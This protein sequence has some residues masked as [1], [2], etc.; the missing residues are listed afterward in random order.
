MS[1]GRLTDDATL[2]IEANK[3]FSQSQRIPRKPV[4][5]GSGSTA[6]S[7]STAEMGLPVPI[8]KTPLAETDHSAMHRHERLIRKDATP[9]PA[10]KKY[11]RWGVTWKTPLLIVLWTLAGVGWAIGHHLYYRSLDG[12]K[13]G[14]SSQQH[15]AVNFGTA[16]AFLVV[17]SLRAACDIV[18]QQYI[19]TVFKRKSLSLDAL[20]KLF[21]VTADPTAFVSWE[22]ITHAKI[23]FLVALMCW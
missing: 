1:R 9:S 15:W 13:A 21:S 17:A 14:S 4:A 23:A 8:D 11:V 20:D 10:Q 22:F 12:T 19:W 5:R 2:S 16:L 6:P 7:L 18:Y 3:A